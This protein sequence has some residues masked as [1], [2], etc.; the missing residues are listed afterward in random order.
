MQTK[1]TE[2]SFFPTLIKMLPCLC[3]LQVESVVFR[4]LSSLWIADETEQL[5]GFVFEGLDCSFALI[6]IDVIGYF[7]GCEF[8][9]I[10]QTVM[11]RG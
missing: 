6:N 5:F 2:N 9:D 1:A 7:F 11:F 10:E 4:Q 8:L 3:F